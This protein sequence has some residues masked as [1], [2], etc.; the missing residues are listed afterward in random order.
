MA[1]FFI[2]GKTNLFLRVYLVLVVSATI[3]IIF[4]SED[5]YIHQKFCVDLHLKNVTKVRKHQIIPSSASDLEWK[6]R[7]IMVQNE[8]E[9][10]RVNLSSPLIKSMTEIEIVNAT[11]ISGK[12]IDFVSQLR[13]QPDVHFLRLNWY[14]KISSVLYHCLPIRSDYYKPFASQPV[15]D[16]Y[17]KSYFKY[18]QW[19]DQ[20]K[21]Q[22]SC[23]TSLFQQHTSPVGL[24]N[25][26][27]SKL[28][29]PRWSTYNS[30]E[31]FSYIVLVKNAYVNKIGSVA[32]KDV[33]IQPLNCYERVINATFDV[34]NAV[35][36]V[37]EVFVTSQTWG[38]GHFYMNAKNL[39]R[40]ALYIEFLQ[41]FPSIYVHMASGPK[42][43]L[44]WLQH[45]EESLRALG[46]NPKRIIRGNVRARIVYLPRSSVCEHML[47]LPEIQVLASRYHHFIQ[48]N[49]FETEHSSLLLIVR[50]SPS[51]NRNIPR[52]TYNKLI[53]QLQHLINKSSL[54]LE[55]FDDRDNPKY[56]DTIRMFYRA[57]IIIGMHGAGLANMIY[58]RPGTQVIEMMCQ[59]PINV[60]FAI[61][62]GILGHRYHA[63][64][65]NGCPRN[66]TIDINLLVEVISM[67]T[68]SFNYVVS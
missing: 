43:S 41:K 23:N 4:F 40:L 60:N 67:Y 28:N 14:E 49:L 46:I 37:D 64:P 42:K 18:P 57:K 21:L 47:L 12:A 66:V 54:V 9:I 38:D 20:W 58:S 59:P 56:Y 11:L 1:N 61:T 52:D 39:P 34:S 30:S 15:C 33:I 55:L 45:A 32:N 53:Q 8:L 27:N 31:L 24:E 48:K 36:A 3:L 19:Y 63:F 16:S 2:C 35:P 22:I 26:L 17:L 50:D 29:P 6:H 10:L 62:A 5:Q 44:R 68:R 13:R 51:G 25:I 7:V 65:A